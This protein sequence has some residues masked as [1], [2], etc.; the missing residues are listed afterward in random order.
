MGNTGM[1]VLTVAGWGRAK[2]KREGAVQVSVSAYVH[3]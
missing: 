2:V 3:V 1:S